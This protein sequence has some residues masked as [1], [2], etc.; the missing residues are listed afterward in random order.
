[1]ILRINKMNLI[2]VYSLPQKREGRKGQKELHSLQE[3]TNEERE[4]ILY[5][6]KSLERLRE[7][8]KQH[9]KN[10]SDKID[11]RAFQHLSWKKTI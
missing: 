11:Y 10:L 6:K 4:K 7:L 2:P 5:D 8:R 3:I 1:M 9:I